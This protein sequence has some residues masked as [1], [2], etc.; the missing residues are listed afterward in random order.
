[1]RLKELRIAQKLYQK[2]IADMLGVDRTT[3]TKYESGA[4]EPDIATLIQLADFFGVTVDYL[5]NHK[6]KGVSEMKAGEINTIGKRI[7]DT[8]EKKGM[9]LDELAEKLEISIVQLFCFENNL[10]KPSRDIVEKIAKALG[11]D[12]QRLFTEWEKSVSS[13]YFQLLHENFE[14]S[15]L[16]RYIIGFFEI[17]G[18][19][20]DFHDDYLS[21]KSNLSDGH[22]IA[23][24]TDF[25]FDAISSVLGMSAAQMF[26]SYSKLSHR[27]QHAI[28][29]TFT[30][31]LK[32]DARDQGNIDNEVMK[33]SKSD[34]YSTQ[35]KSRLA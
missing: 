26:Q 24:F 30:E 3:Y 35:E 12:K 32:L 18:V 27:D 17:N 11:I 9:A 7:K 14:K 23:L 20:Y 4:S 34:R 10:M 21:S 31:Y 8:R 13:D 5:I 22:D 6:E 16:D 28:C 1:M 29:K 33:L 19:P 2:D 15:L 25:V